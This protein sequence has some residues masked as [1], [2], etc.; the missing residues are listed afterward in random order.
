MKLNFNIS[1]SLLNVWNTSQL[2]FYFQYIKKTDADTQVKTCYGLAGNILHNAIE[3]YINKKVPTKDI[4]SFGW[5][6]HKLNELTGLNSKPLNIDDYIKM[7]IRAERI[8]DDYRARGFT[9]ETEVLF[10]H[11]IESNTIKGYVDCVAT[12]KD[13]NTVVILDWKSNSKLD[14]EH[15]KQQLFYAYLYHQKRGFI[16]ERFEWHYLKAEKTLTLERV[17]GVDIVLEHTKIIDFIRTIES[18]ADNVDKYSI[19]D[20]QSPFNPYQKACEKVVQDRMNKNYLKF[21]ITIN[22]LQCVLSGDL[23]E[24]LHLGLEKTLSFTE[25]TAYFKIKNIKKRIIADYINKH[26]HGSK[27][28]AVKE[29]SERTKHI[30]YHCLY[31]RKNQSFPIGLLD[32]VVK[33]LTQYANFTN[34]ILDYKIQDNRI[35]VTKDLD[36][37]I[38]DIVSD[39]KLREYQENAVKCFIDKKIGTL[40]LATGA[41]KTLVMCHI[42]SR[43]KKRTLI[44]I[45]RVELLDQIHEVLTEELNCDIGKIGDTNFDLKDITIATVQTLSRP[46][47]MS[48]VREW[49]SN[50]ELVVVDEFHKAACESFV[51]VFMLLPNAYYKLGLTGTAFRTDNKEMIMFGLIGDVI[52]RISARD[53]IDM[54]YLMKPKITFF[55]V[56]ISHENDKNYAK[57]YDL[58]VV[59]NVWRNAKIE[60]LVNDNK[61]KKILILT[62]LVAKH[63]NILSERIGGYHITGNTNR[64]DRKGYLKEFKDSSEGVLISTTQIASTGLDI[65][66]LDIIINASGNASEITSIQSLGRVLRTS[67]GKLEALYYDFLDAGAFTEKSSRKRIK[68]FEDEGHKVMIV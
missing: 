15:K 59:Q 33:V 52:M 11:E 2:Q 24:K 67:C 47:L 49:M 14:P 65:Q 22:G 30:G 31:N 16:P 45:D 58:S 5:Q 68:Q 39:K 3:E 55:R 21:T 50:V 25:S 51:R 46:N 6:E 48:H 35:I 28:A 34:S 27:L 41:G 54:G 19:G 66:D 63:G 32:K 12:N 7:G 60:Q 42:I 62:K 57:D 37:K 26:G 10:T 61:G 20:Y 23:S 40:E 18:Y 36:N 53:L 56:P 8:I 43:L 38:P 44:L 4:I 29:A 64:E 9:F 17:S 1:Y 13:T